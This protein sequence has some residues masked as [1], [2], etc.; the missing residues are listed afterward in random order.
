[1]PEVVYSAELESPVL[2]E[3]GRANTLTCPA[4]RNGN[5]EEPSAATISIWDA[6]GQ[7][8]VDEAVATI[9]DGVATYITGDFAGSDRGMRW[10]IRWR[11][12]LAGVRV[13]FRSSAGL[14]LCVPYPVVSD[15][16]IYGRVPLLD[17]SAPGAIVRAS[18]HQGAIDDAWRTIRKRLQRSGPRAHL[19]VDQDDLAEPHLCLTI[20]RIFE[21]L[22]VVK[23]EFLEQAK[24]YEQEYEGAWTDLDLEY[25]VDDDGEPDQRHRSPGGLWLCGRS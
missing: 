18:S 23:P 11:L 16:T 25:D 5:L 7:V 20:A 24:R 10:R 9:T 12:T 8:L 1:M 6:A 21:G 3:Q 13:T 22:G 15:R 4:R 14:V 2:L 17:A 19:V